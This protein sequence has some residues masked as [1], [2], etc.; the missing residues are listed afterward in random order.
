MIFGDVLFIILMTVFYSSP[1]HAQTALQIFDGAI[2]QFEQRQRSLHPWQYYQT[3][4]TRQYDDKGNVIGK[5]IWRALVR[6]GAQPPIEYIAGSTEGEL[7]LFDKPAKS[8]ASTDSSGSSQRTVAE[9][10]LHEESS[11]PES[12]VEAVN[13][14]HLRD[15]YYW[16]RL[17]DARVIGETAYV[18]SFTPKENQTQTSGR[19][20]RFF[21]LLAGKLWISK[22]DHSILKAEAALQAPMSLLWIVA[23][24][25]HL[26]FTWEIIPTRA[27]PLLRRSHGES[28]L[29]IELPFKTVRQKH[30]L[31]VDKYER[32]PARK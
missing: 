6:P 18:L 9:K 16:K 2:H 10:E 3:L 11:R 25:T 23:R 27:N 22:H 1:V 15:R 19:E 28:S 4:V 17:P 30:Q 5:G 21:S 13:K 14:Y 31:T 12:V 32:R 8:K 24:I 7:T 20:A 26:E 29:T